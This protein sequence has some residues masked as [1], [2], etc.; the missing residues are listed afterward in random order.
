MNIIRRLKT[1][2]DLTPVTAAEIEFYY[3]GD[4]DVLHSILPVLKLEKER[5]ENQYEVAFAPAS[6]EKTAAD[7]VT[8][9]TAAEALGADFSAKPFA[10]Q[11]GSGLHIHIHLADK[12]GKNVFYKDDDAISD[13][14]KYAIGGLLAA[15]PKSMPIFAPN[16]ESHAR[17]QPG[18]NAPTTV[19]WGANNRTVAMRLPDKPH[20]NKHIEHRVAGADADPHAVIAAILEAIHDG[21]ARQLDPG[22]QI[23]GDASLEMYKLPK[24]A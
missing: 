22:P 5:G 14:L 2:F 21:L 15:L 20:D 4:I 18:G 16:P 23:Y 13:G 24:L 17:F 6:P 11:P 7:L 3:S 1:D 9:K 12:D 8:F 10:D 19:S